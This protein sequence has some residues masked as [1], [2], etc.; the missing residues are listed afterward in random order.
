LHIDFLIL[1][2]DTVHMRDRIAAPSGHWLKTPFANLARYVPS[3]IYFSRIR[4]R[5]KL[6]RRSLKTN[7]LAVARLRLGDLEK[8][9]RQ[10]SELRGAIVSGNMTFGDA[11]AVFSNRVANDN[12]LKPRS[13]EYRQERVAA[14]L[15]SWPGLEKTEVRK[16]SKHDCLTW[17]ATFGQ[18]ASPSN[19]NNTVGSLWMIIEVAID[20]GARYDNPARFIKKLRVRQKELQLP[21]RDEFLKMVESIEGVNRR[22]SQ[23]RHRHGRQTRRHRSWLSQFAERQ[24]L[25]IIKQ[26]QGQVV[27][28]FCAS[29]NPFDKFRGTIIQLSE[30][31]ALGAQLIN[32]CRIKF[33]AN[34]G[35]TRTGTITVKGQTGAV[36]QA[37]ASYIGTIRAHLRG[38]PTDRLRPSS[39]TGRGADTDWPW[40]RLRSRTGSEHGPVAGWTRPRIGH[41]LPVTADIGAAI[42]P[43][44][45][46]FYRV[47]CADTKTSF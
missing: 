3:G 16:I 20:A 15:K 42:R 38:L 31:T 1:Q 36:T 46:R 33:D 27:R 2:S 25:Q 17:A 34:T 32:F 21:N 43:D 13:K 12:S 45:L 8:V 35:S 4:V 7:K 9:E 11:L 47:H 10:R 6:I 39:R 28:L 23:A 19:F 29:H 26:L 14:L 37:G 5:G 41:G 24:S 30:I 22:F 40:T 44:R 18:K